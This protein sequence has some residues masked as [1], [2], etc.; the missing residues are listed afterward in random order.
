[1]ATALALRETARERSI[2]LPPGRNA[3]ACIRATA[4]ASFFP[5]FA[6]ISFA[7]SFLQLR[8]DS[9]AQ[10]QSGALRVFFALFLLLVSYVSMLAFTFP[11]RKMAALANFIRAG[12]KEKQKPGPM[13]P[14]GIW[15]P[16]DIK[17]VTAA[18]RNRSHAY[19]GH[20]L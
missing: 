2:D 8:E 11:A 20:C 19:S 18:V 10:E 3:R 16:D 5:L 12:G 4:I 15:P 17:P 1:M 6:F 7:V 14:A 13:A 9:S